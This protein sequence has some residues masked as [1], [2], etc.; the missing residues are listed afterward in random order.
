ML[1]EYTIRGRDRMVVRLTATY[2][3]NSILPFHILLSFGK[4]NL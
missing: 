2:S 4:D 3:I 1:I